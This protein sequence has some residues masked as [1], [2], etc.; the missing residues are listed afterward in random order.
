MPPR[1][2]WRERAEVRV[3]ERELIVNADDFGRSLATNAGI[4]RAHEYGIVTSAS[5]MV[6]WPAA[7]HAARYVREH[8]ELGLG[9]H[10][11][12]GEWAHR[13]G[14][15]VR[16]YERA[17]I[18]EE[19][20]R[21]L[22][23]FRALVGHDPTHLDSHQHVHREQPAASLMDAVA[24]QLDIPLRDR[25]AIRYCGDFYG[26]TGKGEPCPDA[27]TV[28][29]LISVLERLEIGATE[30][31]CHPGLDPDLDSAYRL[32]R[33]REVEALCDPRVRLALDRGRVRLRA[34]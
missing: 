13:K 28:E 18:D 20:G 23:R 21:Q 14:E 15:W 11:D 3:S 10:V 33:L 25:G 30:L 9:L 19:I 26:Q 5:L 34:F 1:S 32:E 4:I 17:P 29:A 7:D 16:V 8:P 12:L 6:R 31:G 2:S 22:E 24:E 27:I